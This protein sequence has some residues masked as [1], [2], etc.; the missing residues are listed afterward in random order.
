MNAEQFIG[1]V[2]SLGSVN[3]LVKEYPQEIAPDFKRFKNTVKHRIKGKQKA[4]MSYR[5][6]LGIK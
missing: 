4:I 5:I 1:L 2:L 3:R 6:R